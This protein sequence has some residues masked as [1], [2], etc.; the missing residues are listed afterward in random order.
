[1]EVEHQHQHLFL[2]IMTDL[3]SISTDLV[4]SCLLQELF[5][6]QEFYW[7]FAKSSLAPEISAANMSKMATHTVN[8]V[9]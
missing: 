8:S 4:V 2:G 1:M 9:G 7:H 5:S 3:Q 6:V